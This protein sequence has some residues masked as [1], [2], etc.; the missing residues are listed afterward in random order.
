[1]PAATDLAIAAASGGNL[2][3][4]NAFGLIVLAAS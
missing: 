1:M 4:T 2:S 3:K